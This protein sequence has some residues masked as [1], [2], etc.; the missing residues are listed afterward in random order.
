MSHYKSVCQFGFVHG[1]CRCP[2][3]NKEIR[4]IECPFTQGHSYNK[5]EE[6]QLTV[7]T[8]GK[9]LIN[10]KPLVIGLTGFAGSGKDTV[11][12]EF[13]RR[14]W[15]RVSFAAGVYALALAIDP[16]IEVGPGHYELLSVTVET[17]GWMGS[18]WNYPDVRR[19]LQ[20]VGNE[21]RE[22]IGKTVWVD[23]AQKQIDQYTS[24]G[25]NVVITDVRYPNESE[26]VRS[27]DNG[28]VV[29]VERPGVG[30]IN[31]HIS[32]KGLSESQIDAVLNNDGALEDIPRK[33]DETLREIL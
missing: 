23:L 26:M 1:Q 16:W 20:N 22:V 8:S 29:K 33:V 19:I 5:V 30:P 18:K 13:I 17:V 14:G 10:P 21:A 4:R 28:F 9:T 11:G 7:N 31:G 32:D 15:K 3:P 6:Q 2:D 25:Y 27:L 24:E 12:E